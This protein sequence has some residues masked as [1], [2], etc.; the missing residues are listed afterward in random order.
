MTTDGTREPLLDRAFLDAQTFGDAA[1]A[2][3]LL[4]L[5]E[6]QCARLV[7]VIADA[8]LLAEARGD[9]AHTLRGAAQAIGARRVA[10]LAAGVEAAL[11]GP[12][13]DASTEIGVALAAA[14]TAT[15]AAS[16]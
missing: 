10:A 1:L 7:P 6:G 8:D 3:E 5:F 15:C 13:S 4:R 2:A 9:A 11:A 12:G 16:A 14:A